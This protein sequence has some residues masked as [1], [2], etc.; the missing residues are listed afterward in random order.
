[1]NRAFTPRGAQ[2]VLQR[3]V[4]VQQ[5]LL[6]ADYNARSGLSYMAVLDLEKAYDRV[7]R[8][9]LLHTASKWLH[10]NLL[11]MVR[12]ILGPLLMLCKGDP[13]KFKVTMTLC[14]MHMHGA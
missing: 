14:I 10:L 3:G 12:C 9:M 11:N 6:T 4:S 2:F 13:T 8:R 7:D 1:M 5:A